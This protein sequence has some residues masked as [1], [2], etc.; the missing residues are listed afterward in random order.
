MAKRDLDIFAGEYALGTLDA[1]ERAEAERLLQSDAGFARHVRD[2]ERRLSP[3]SEA[4]EAVQPPASAWGRIASAISTG[5]VAASNPL[6]ELA[7]QLVELKRS[8]SI[9]RYA[10]MTAMAA[11]LAL[12]VVWLGGLQSPFQPPAAPEERYVAMLKSDDGK[13]GFVVTMNMDGK[14]FAIKPVAAK[15]P[16]GHSYELWAIMKDK[17]QPMTLGLV[18]TS[19]YAMMDAP[20]V[21]DSKELDKGVEL[22]IS[23]EPMGGAPKGQ[24]MGPV[25]YAGLLVKATP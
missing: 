20:P 9:W 19:A 15:Q 14:Q 6:S 3:L 13:M 23:M 22:A 4:G 1:E 2:W 18:Q 17:K 12:A 24:P 11:A 21:L 16:E 10:T 8:L 7:G 5:T 25:M